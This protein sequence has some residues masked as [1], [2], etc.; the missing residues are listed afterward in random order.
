[1]LDL[2]V[3]NMCAKSIFSEE[4]IINI[5]SCLHYWRQVDIVKILSAKMVKN[6]LQYLRPGFDPWIGKIPLR[7]AW[8]P[9]SIFLLGENPWTEEPGGLQSMGLQRVRHHWMAKHSRMAK[10]LLAVGWMESVNWII[11]SIIT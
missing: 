11:L 5:M 8:Q 3:L 4:D 10:Y 6:C 9:I 1:M 7:G 2:Y